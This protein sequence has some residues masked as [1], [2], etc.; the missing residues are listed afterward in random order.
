MV[1]L[2]NLLCYLMLILVQWILSTGEVTIW[3]NDPKVPN[4]GWWTEYP[5]VINLNRN[6]REVIFADFDGDGKCDIVSSSSREPY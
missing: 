3:V 5:K 1:G 4:W 2:L 6:R